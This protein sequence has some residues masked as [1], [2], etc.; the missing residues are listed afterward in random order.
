MRH[1]QLAQVPCSHL[2]A[3]ARHAEQG[4]PALHGRGAQ[5]A[6]EG[7]QRSGRAGPGS[8]C[9]AGWRSA[10][11]GAQLQQGRY[12]PCP[13]GRESGRE[14][15]FLIQWRVAG[16]AAASGGARASRSAG[17]GGMPSRWGRRNWSWGGPGVPEHGAQPAVVS[18]SGMQSP[19]IQDQVRG[20]PHKKRCAARPPPPSKRGGWDSSVASLSCSSLLSLFN[21]QSSIKDTRIQ[22]G[23]E[24]VY[25]IFL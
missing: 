17:E 3:A 7:A 20:I 14:L 11:P 19:V 23:L 15:L 2:P 25:I 12:G 10:P 21:M 5:R 18:T 9:R 24:E 4:A 8:Y 13:G 16:P 1:Q 22:Q 6:W